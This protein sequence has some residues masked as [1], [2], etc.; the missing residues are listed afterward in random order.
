MGSYLQNYGAGEERRIS[1]FKRI[2][3]IGLA[4]IVV[5][6]AL[7]LFFHNYPEKQ[8]VKRFLAQLNNHQ[9]AE[10]YKT[11]NCAADQTCRSYDYQRFLEDWGPSKNI[12]S[13]WK[14]ASVD[15][16]KAFVTV[17]VQAK[18]SELESLSVIR[19]SDG[20]G[21]APS[22]EC[23]EKKIRLGQFFHR[24]FHGT[25]APAPPPAPR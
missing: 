9:Y 14:I 19:G 3:L 22:P 21:F 5:G 12:S 25:P 8:L 24:L 13:P 23:Q 2:G 11:W 20:I 7:Y 16:C 18:G 4:V 15:G 1:L 17:N 10:A 6:I